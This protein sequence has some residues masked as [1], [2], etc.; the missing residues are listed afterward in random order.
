MTK[1][2]EIMWD[3]QKALPKGYLIT[4]SVSSFQLRAPNGS[5]NNRVSAISRVLSRYWPKDCQRHKDAMSRERA[6]LAILRHA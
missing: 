3:I 4:K 6:K 2:F 5:V 1:D